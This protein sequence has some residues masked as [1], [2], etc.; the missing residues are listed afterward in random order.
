MKTKLSFLILGIIVGIILF[1]DPFHM[2]SIDEWLRGSSS[3]TFEKDAKETQLW[4]CGMHPDVIQDHPGTCPICQMDLVPLQHAAVSSEPVSQE[5]KI[6]YTCPMHPDILQEE[7]GE[8][9]V[10]GMDLVQ[11][12]R[13]HV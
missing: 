11:I 2:H 1:L 12:G 9:P 8:C 6:L 10:C 3:V 13:A 5:S 7:P 4:T